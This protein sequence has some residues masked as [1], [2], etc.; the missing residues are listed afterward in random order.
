MNMTDVVYKVKLDIGI[1]G[2]A[3]PFDN[4]DKE[5]TECIERSTLKTFSQYQPY[6]EYFQCNLKDLEK[7][8]KFGTTETYLLPDFHD[9]P[10][11]FVSAVHYDEAELSGMGYWGGGMPLVTGNIMQQLMLSN[12]ANQTV[13]QMMPKMTFKF[14][15]PRTITLFNVYNSRK[16]VMILAREHDK[17]LASIP[18]TCFESFTQLAALDVKN[19]LYNVMRHYN[20][21]ESG[22]GH[23]TLKIDD[24]ANAKQERDELINR[25]EDTYHLD[26]DNIEWG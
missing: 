9:R 3:L 19:F 22:Y 26:Q 23:I 17:T 15:Y 14:F 24:W 12:V 16:V 1:Y 6:Y 11:L 5:I 13:Q 21:V 2:M 10:I 18:D 8:K 25:W 20:D 4:I 7:I